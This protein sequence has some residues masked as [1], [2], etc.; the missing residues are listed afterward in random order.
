VAVK[1]RCKGVFKRGLS[2]RGLSK[3]VWRRLDTADRH[4]VD[5][6]R[7]SADVARH[8]AG[9]VAVATLLP[10]FPTHPSPLPCSQGLGGVNADNEYDSRV[11]SLA[12]LLCST[13]V[14]N[15]MGR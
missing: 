12:V 5:A 11:F 2:K 15:S 14:Y 9:L 8:S 10:L 1:A 3:G 4:P 7:R 13:L 6:A